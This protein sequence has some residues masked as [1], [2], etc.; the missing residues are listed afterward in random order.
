M[1][2]GS[3]LMSNSMTF[4]L[5]FHIVNVE[6]YVP[7]KITGY[8]YCYMGWYYIMPND[9]ENAAAGSQDTA[10]LRG[11]PVGGGAHKRIY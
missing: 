4:F 11:E 5:C 6:C 3:I 10:S 8:Q 9:A 7:L 2:G 1:W